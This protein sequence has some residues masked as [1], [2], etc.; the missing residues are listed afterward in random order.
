MRTLYLI[1]GLQGSGKSTLAEKL[2][3]EYG[4]EIFSADDYFTD[5]DGNYHYD[6]RQV[7]TAHAVCQR[8]ARLHMQ[9]P[10]MGNTII[11]NTFAQRW[12]MEPYLLMAREFGFQVC[13]IDL[14]DGGLTNAE[15][16]SRNIH[17]VPIESIAV[18]RGRWEHNWKDSNPNPPRNRR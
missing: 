4:D 11:A 18:T 8:A 3:R 16:E 7:P 17:S 15:L 2:V 12:E 6:S 9:C 10:T 13:V 14:Y 5:T 1:R